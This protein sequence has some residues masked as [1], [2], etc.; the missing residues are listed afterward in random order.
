MARIETLTAADHAAVGELLVEA[1]SDYTH[2]V[3][4]GEWPRLRN[5]LATAADNLPDYA[6]PVAWF[7]SARSP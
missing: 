2:R 4:P 7:V 6:R 3:G 1:Y 5:G